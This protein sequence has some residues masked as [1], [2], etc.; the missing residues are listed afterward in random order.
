MLVIVNHFDRKFEAIP[1]CLFCV[2]KPRS[3][4]VNEGCKMPLP[5]S[6]AQLCARLCVGYVDS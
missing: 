6:R 5:D 4:V 2:P 1:F 3:A